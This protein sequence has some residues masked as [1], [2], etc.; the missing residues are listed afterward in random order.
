M[1]CFSILTNL[2]AYTYFDDF[3]NYILLCHYE[4]H[5]TWKNLQKKKKICLVIDPPLL[6][7]ILP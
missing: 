2:Y 1:A 7:G 4:N 3:S 5:L 6:H